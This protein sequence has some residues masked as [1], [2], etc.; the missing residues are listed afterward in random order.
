MFEPPGSSIGR[1]VERDALIRGY[2]PGAWDMFHI[3]HLN[4]LRRARGE[5]DHLIVGVVT[6]QALFE[7][8]GKYPVIPVEERIE[9]LESVAIVDQ[10]V[11]DYGPNKIE[12]WRRVGF[13]ILFKGDDWMG[14]EKGRRLEADMASIGVKVH[15]FPYTKST[16]STELRKHLL[17]Y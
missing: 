5:C 17:A 15:Y 13:D 16:N 10:V 7:M 14:T 12:V 2:V 8:K 3:G 9:I 1:G 11:P 6:D 4:I